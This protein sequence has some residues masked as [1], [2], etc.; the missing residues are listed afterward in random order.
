MRVDEVENAQTE[1]LAALSQFL[2]GLLNDTQNTGEISIARFCKMA[3]NLGISVTPRSL[4]NLIKKEPL[5]NY[6]T[7]VDASSDPDAGM[8]RFKNADITAEP[9]KAAKPN[10]NQSIVDKLAKRASNRLSNR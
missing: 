2:I 7:S 6:I 3:A 5:R 9:E 10:A 8:I 1:R 4:P